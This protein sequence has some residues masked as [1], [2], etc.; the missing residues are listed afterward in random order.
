MAHPDFRAARWRKSNNSGDG[1]CVEVALS[2]GWI[3]V[4]DTKDQGSG[5]ILA[6]TLHEWNSFLT[7]AHN[8]EFAPERLAD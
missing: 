4:R 3:G 5:P 1:G 6:F 2:D 8:G 7:G